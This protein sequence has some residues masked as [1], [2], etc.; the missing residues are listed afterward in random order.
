VIEDELAVAGWQLDP[1][2]KALAAISN[3]QVT[4]LRYLQL[5]SRGGDE[6]LVRAL[7]NMRAS[8]RD[9]RLAVAVAN[10]S[11]G[12]QLAWSESA[13]FKGIEE[14]L[15]S[16]GQAADA[17]PWHPDA[18]TVQ[19]KLPASAVVLDFA[20]YARTEFPSQRPGVRHLLVSILTKEG[21]PQLVDLGAFDRIEAAVLE[22]RTAIQQQ[23]EATTDRVAAGLAGSLF[24]PLRTLL[25]DASVVVVVPDSTLHLLPFDVLRK[26]AGWPAT[27]GL[28]VAAS[29]YQALAKAPTEAATPAG[30]DVQIVAAPDYGEPQPDAAA[31]LSFAPLPGAAE[32][33]KVL[34]QLWGEEQA[35]LWSGSAASETQLRALH[36]PRILHL[37]THGY[38]RGAQAVAVD[39][40]G[41]RGLGVVAAPAQVPVLSDKA[42]GGFGAVGNRVLSR[43]LGSYDDPLLR[44][45]IALSGANDPDGE[46][47][48]NG[49]LDG[50]EVTALDL[51]GTELVVLSACETAV[52]ESLDGSA[53][54]S[55]QRA[56]H[57]AGAQW[58]LSTLWPID[59]DATAVLM[60]AF[61]QELRA[62]SD[63]QAALVR[64][65]QALQAEPKWQQ[66]YFWAAFQLSGPLRASVR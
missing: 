36:A 29:L 59:D 39:A 25:K 47:A 14:R 56:F 42:F 50:R 23:D 24:T 2:A 58:V 61:H 33:G 45:G 66:P 35:Q 44:V 13:W 19:S 60:Q 55:L 8:R 30:M 16:P 40:S 65:K 51:Q 64:A 32:E 10:P 52:G 43:L 9:R 3:V 41:T 62:G 27:R 54:G 11:A 18:K 26:P 48:S 63:P 15:A 46:A 34:M 53:V 57:R 28:Q 22:L 5:A 17:E 38:A 6:A 49:I 1:G 31:A 20:V 4:E 12:N 21:A 37:A 7:L